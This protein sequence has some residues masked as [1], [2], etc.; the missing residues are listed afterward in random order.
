ML[1]LNYIFFKVIYRS[2]SNQD[3]GAT[4]NDFEDEKAYQNWIELKNYNLIG[5][6]QKIKK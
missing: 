3:L 5:D 1:L 4:T 2:Q 6:H